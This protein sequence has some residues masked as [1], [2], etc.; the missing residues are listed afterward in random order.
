MLYTCVARAAKSLGRSARAV[1]AG[2][3]IARASAPIKRLEPNGELIIA[4]AE[5]FICVSIMSEY[6]KSKE[7][8]LVL[9]KRPRPGKST[10][11]RA[12][13]HW[14][15]T[16]YEPRDGKWIKHERLMGKMIEAPSEVDKRELRK[17]VSDE[18]EREIIWGLGGI[19]EN[20]KKYVR[21]KGYS[22]KSSIIGL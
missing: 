7:E 3:A 6:A 17:Y 20:F 1:Y 19:K 12:W 10:V 2:G 8:I 21:A 15:V 11:T 9:V 16:I 4:N 13:Y 14:K 18:V 22:S 5:L